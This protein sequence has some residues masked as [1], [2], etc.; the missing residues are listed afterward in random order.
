MILTT[1][2]SGQQ[3]LKQKKKE[4]EDEKVAEN[5]DTVIRA[6]VN[7]LPKKKEQVKNYVVKLTMGKPVKFKL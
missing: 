6:V 4:M 3:F 7:I 2:G 5:I 1:G